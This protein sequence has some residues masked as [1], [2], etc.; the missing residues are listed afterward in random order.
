M[1]PYLIFL[2]LLDDVDSHCGGFIC[3][4]LLIPL[5]QELLKGVVAPPVNT[6]QNQNESITMYVTLQ[7]IFGCN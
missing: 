2:N 4:E 7:G 6:I 5:R 3:L 1:I